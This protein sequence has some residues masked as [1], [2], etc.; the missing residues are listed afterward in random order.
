MSELVRCEQV[1]LGWSTNSLLGGDGFGPVFASAGWRL[2]FGDRDAGLGAR[3]RFLDRGA[4][5]LVDDGAA[6]PRCLAYE[7]TD[8][9]SLLVSRAYAAGAAR[10]GQYVV[11][12]LLDPSGRLGPRDLFHCADR[13]LLR[14]E[15]PAGEADAGW[16]AVEVALAEPEES[17]GLDADAEAVLAGP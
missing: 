13:G 5:A 14:T 7:P 17:P 9:G 2:P 12:A 1:M 8:H 10:P 15:Q 16:P 4:A 3:A 11:H 6:P